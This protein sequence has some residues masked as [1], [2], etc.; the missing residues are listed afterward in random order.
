MLD[1]EAMRARAR[2]AAYEGDVEEAERWFRRSIELFREL[3]TP[4]FQARAQIQYA[5]LIGGVDDGVAAR[6]EAASI[7]ESLGATPWLER[8]RPLTSEVVA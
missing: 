2:L 6:E 3:A 8:A 4:F 1:A 7:F 5:E